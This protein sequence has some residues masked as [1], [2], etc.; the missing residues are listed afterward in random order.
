MQKK[1]PWKLVLTLCAIVVSP[2]LYY[3]LSPL[4]ITVAIDEASPVSLEGGGTVQAL[5]RQA[6]VVDTPLHPATGTVSLLTTPDGY[7]VRY[8]EYKTINGP[9][10]FVYLSTDVDATEFVDLGALKATEGNVNYA[11][12][13]GTD[14]EKYRYVLTWCKQFG[15]LF[16]S[17]D[18]RA[19]SREQNDV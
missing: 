11:V 4:F 19:Q 12:P 6:P 9:D 15:V 8:E 18:L 16:N 10:L 7:V 5:V 17:A 13:P 14:I 2:L 3:A 1:F